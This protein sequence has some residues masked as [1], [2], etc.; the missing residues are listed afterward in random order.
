MFD[1]S[2]GAFVH[3]SHRELT[4]LELRNIAKTRRAQ[5]LKVVRQA[6]FKDYNKKFESVLRAKERFN[7][8]HSRVE[9]KLKRLMYEGAQNSLAVFRGGKLVRHKPLS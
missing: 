1:S 8:C 6:A 7:S 3:P 2:V 4:A 9:T 5:E